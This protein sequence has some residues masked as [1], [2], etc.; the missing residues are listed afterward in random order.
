[1]TDRILIIR[2]SALGDVCRTVPV[3][4]SLRR[5]YPDATIDWLVRDTWQESIIAHPALNDAVPFPRRRLGRSMARLNPLPS[6]AWMSRLSRRRYDLV[7]DAQGLARS[8]LFAWATR[9]PR[10]V[11]Y[12]DAREAAPIAYTKRVHAAR[13]LHTV[14]RMLALL[15]GIEIDVVKDMRLFAPQA[16]RRT[17]ADD[18]RFGGH[19]VLAPTSIWPG[20][21]W[22]IHRFAELAQRLL[23]SGAEPIVIV[24]APGEQDQCEPLAE[25][26]QHDDRVIDMVGR[27]GIGTLMA[28]VESSRLVVANDSAV[29]HMAVGFDR[30]AVA[31]FGPTRTELVGPYGRDDDVIQHVRGGETLDHKND[32]AGRALMDRITTDEVFDAAMQRLTRDAP[33]SPS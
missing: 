12:A 10:R 32:A 26:A 17:I 25:L 33:Q 30:P 2:P 6:L 13:T 8:A 5:A 29:L 7:I 15:H 27:T 14:D 20:K 4:A 21:R 11:G 18:A 16:D 19:V 23:A 1:M 28:L 9:A 24:G 22:P 31:L 3:L